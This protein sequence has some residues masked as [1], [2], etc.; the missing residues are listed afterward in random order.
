MPI[1]CMLT[2]L[3]IAWCVFGYAWAGRAARSER[4]GRCPARLMVS[5]T[6]G[7]GIP[8][9]GS[10]TRGG[11]ASTRGHGS[12]ASRAAGGPAPRPLA[13][14]TPVLMHEGGVV[15]QTESIT[16]PRWNTT[17]SVSQAQPTHQSGPGAHTSPRPSH[18]PGRPPDRDTPFRAR[19]SPCMVGGRDVG[20]ERAASAR[21][22]KAAPS[23]QACPRRCLAGRRPRGA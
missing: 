21:V 9:Q 10:K 13:P 6:P 3:R 17:V 16:A 22:P 7:P 1:A 19:P 20:L 14:L 18:T 23:G 12:P 11:T 15:L 2:F 8:A 4:T 5:E